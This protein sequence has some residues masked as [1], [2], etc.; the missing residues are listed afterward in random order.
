VL[1]V[2]ALGWAFAVAGGGHS[3]SAEYD[4]GGPGRVASQP[5]AVG[6][7]PDSTVLA[8]TAAS[9]AKPRGGL[10]SQEA[11]DRQL[12]EE[13][14]RDREAGKSSPSP[15]AAAKSLADGAD[16]LIAA[17]RAEKAA[18]AAR[19]Q[20]EVAHAVD[21]ETS[22]HKALL[23]DLAPRIAAGRLDEAVALADQAA[24]DYKTEK[25]R[26]IAQRDA[27]AIRA[28]LGAR[29]LALE[30]L[31]TRVGKRESLALRAGTS[32]EG[33]I[34]AVSQ[35]QG[36]VTV[37]LSSGGSFEIKVAALSDQAV[38][39]LVR[40]VLGYH[41]PPFLL[42][43]GLRIAYGGDPLKGRG[44]I[45]QAAERGVTGAKEFLARVDELCREKGLDPGAPQVASATP[46]E[47][48]TAKPAPEG[49]E[50]D[51]SKDEPTVALTEAVLRRLFE[52]T[53]TTFTPDGRVVFHYVFLNGQKQ[54]GGDFD[55]QGGEVRWDPSISVLKLEGDARR[56]THRAVFSGDV[57]VC[58]DVIY[59]S[60]LTRQS[61]LE[62][63]L[64]D[65]KSKAAAAI[66]SVF[67]IALADRR[68]GK[69]AA[70][71]GPTN[72]LEV[73]TREMKTYASYEWRLV[74]EGTTA[75]TMLDG[76]NR[77]TLEGVQPTQ[78]R[79]VLAWDH[80]NAQLRELTIE[81]KLDMRWVTRELAKR[82]ATIGHGTR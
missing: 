18:D 4:R 7:R 25:V 56:V 48:A 19:A 51:G 1:G 41:H 50:D 65:A 10:F 8:S 21:E 30:A 31:A 79:V 70:V 35:E 80:V 71:A 17:T 32:L 23:S 68:K 76:A 60:E 26:A 47:P 73:W 24:A 62:I 82:A 69:V 38:A 66:E 20:S 57:R 43:D 16:R 34:A 40:A 81:G 2:V 77:G 54:L 58:A 42:D 29:A 6:P 45:A 13:G 33:E 46:A 75:T 53:P 78:R 5:R 14:A 39:E 55:V 52:N 15:E 9:S 63:A 3:S 27:A 28:A 74:L 67:G 61:V 12:A 72:P 59:M 36:T 22:K 44:L 11:S 37:H 49:G 64:E